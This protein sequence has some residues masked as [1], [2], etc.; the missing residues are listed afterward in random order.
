MAKMM[1][2]SA[3]RIRTVANTS[4]ANTTADSSMRRAV[5]T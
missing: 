4:T 2:S 5:V 1:V 3:S